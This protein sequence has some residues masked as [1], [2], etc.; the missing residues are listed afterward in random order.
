[1]KTATE[2]KAIQ[3]GA[4]VKNWFGMEYHASDELIHWSEVQNTEA[5]KKRVEQLRADWDL[6]NSTPEISAAFKRLREAFISK[7]FSEMAETEA[8]ESL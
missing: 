5:F 1:M 8:G 3:T 4:R 7:K 2:R 6:I